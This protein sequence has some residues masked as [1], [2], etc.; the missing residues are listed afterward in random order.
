MSDALLHTIRGCG[1][2]SDRSIESNVRWCRWSPVL[3]GRRPTVPEFL[4]GKLH[5][6]IRSELGNRVLEEAL[7]NVELLTSGGPGVAE[8]PF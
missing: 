2:Y 5:H 7:A 1:A 4:A 8:P 6:E 3:T